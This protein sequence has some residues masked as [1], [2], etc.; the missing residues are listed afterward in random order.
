MSHSRRIKD[1]SASDPLLARYFADIRQFPRLSREEEVL[2][3]QRIK[4]REGVE[5]P[6]DLVERNLKFVVSVALKFRGRGVPLEDLINEGN[7]GLI[8]A[9]HRYDSSK[10]AR[11]TSYAVWWI[12]KMIRQAI[13]DQSSVVRVPVY[14]RVRVRRIRETERTLR[15]RLGRP[16]GRDEIAGQLGQTTRRIETLLHASLREISLDGWPAPDGERGISDVIADRS[17]I[18]PEEQVL[19]DEDIVLV[20]RAL[21]G[22]GAREQTV[23]RCRYGI[24][25]D[26]PMTL[27][28]LGE[29]MGVS[30]EQV[31]Q[32]EVQAKEK[33]RRALKRWRRAG[34]ARLSR[35]SGGISARRPGRHREI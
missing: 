18:S 32:I 14:S 31:R 8:E 26:R 23:I 1:R 15:G 10:G 24:S 16:P 12:Q 9:A 21:D 25:G 34:A 20:R 7:V 4:R 33:I 17:A 19:R 11:F 30:R 27:S 2:L 22:L 6:N 13:A 3:A 28:E 5:T 29:S 35:S